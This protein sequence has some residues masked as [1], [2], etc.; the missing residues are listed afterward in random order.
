MIS[1][2]LDLNYF[3]LFMSIQLFYITY[4]FLNYPYYT[5]HKTTGSVKLF[6]SKFGNLFHIILNYNLNNYL[7]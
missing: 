4:H 5:Y 7:S 6:I 2:K 1:K 3:K